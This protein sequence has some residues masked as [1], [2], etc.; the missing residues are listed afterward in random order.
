MAGITGQGTTFNLPN[1][2][3]ELFC[4]TPQDT[5]FLS[6]IGGL[7][8]G[9]EANGLTSHS[10]QTYDLRATSATRQRLEGADAPTAEARVRANVENVLEIHQ[11]ALELS[12]TKLAAINQIAASGR[13]HAQA[14]SLSGSNPVTDELDWQI[15]QHIIMKARDI[16]ATF[17]N[18][19]Y[20]DPAT[21]ATAR[22]TRGLLEAIATNVVDLNDANVTTAGVLKDAVLD[23]MQECWENGGIS[24]EE[25][26]TLMCNA[27][28]KRELTRE[29]VTASGYAEASRNVGGVA[30]TTIETDFG[31]VN[32]MLNRH[33]PTDTVVVVSLEECSPVFL[34]IPGKGHFFVEPLAKSGSAEKVQ[35]YGEIGL[36]Y[37]DEMKHGKII[38]AG[39]F[40]S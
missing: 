23:L 5:P 25:T 35:L 27:S 31:K 4:L 7:T 37:G 21:N 9:T 40:G 12:Y 17:I 28:I 18:G 8:G 32:I 39:G 2:T 33:M 10:W 22:R 30:V 20:A 26:R 19:T 29:F 15:K 24:V 11:E 1:Y 14:G 38:D 3:G 36:N 13:G 34:N 16:E 6:S